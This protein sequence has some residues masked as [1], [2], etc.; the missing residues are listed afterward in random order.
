V[1]GQPLDDRPSRWV[2][3]GLVGAIECQRLVRHMLKY[4]R[5]IVKQW[6]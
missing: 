5:G 4:H 6:P 3:E 1:R 2:G